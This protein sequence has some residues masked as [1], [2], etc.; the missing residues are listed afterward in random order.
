MVMKRT[1]DC[2]QDEDSNSGWSSRPCHSHNWGS[3]WDRPGHM[4][5]WYHGKVAKMEQLDWKH[6]GILPHFLVPSPDPILGKIL[7]QSLQVRTMQSQYHVSRSSNTLTDICR[8]P[9][10]PVSEW[11]RQSDSRH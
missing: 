11:N 3:P 7:R 9:P 2:S 1:K 10:C 6:Q 5:A 8:S 4:Y